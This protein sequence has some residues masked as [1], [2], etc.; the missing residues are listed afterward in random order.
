M[1]NSNL[2]KA[3]VLLLNLPKQQVSDLL[4]RLEPQQAAAVT[5]EMRGLREVDRAECEA[6]ARDFAADGGTHFGERRPA[7]TIPF[8][9][10]HDLDCDTLLN[11]I[12]EEHPQTIALVLSYLPPRQA[13]TVLAELPP[14]GQLAV[15][16]RIALLSEASRE[17]IRDVEDGLRHHLHGAMSPP[18]AN[19]GV[20]SVVRM[21]HVMEPTSERELLGRLADADPELVR[22]IRRAM[23]GVD[24]AGCDAWD[25][26]EAAG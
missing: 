1:A 3:A 22:E 20:A 24:V 13:A 11:L 14:E 10:L 7:A 17:V 21:L 2:R 12:A 15:V 19:R 6:V 18:A 4:G 16:C 9:F 26:A 8:Q 23:F 5:A 25:A